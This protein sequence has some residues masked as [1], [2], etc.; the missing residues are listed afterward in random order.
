MNFYNLRALFL[1]LIFLLS[2]FFSALFSPAFSQE[3]ADP[4]LDHL[5][6]ATRFFFSGDLDSAEKEFLFTLALNPRL[7]RAHFGLGLIYLRRNQLEEAEKSFRGAIEIQREYAPAFRGLGEVYEQKKDLSNA[8]IHFQKAVSLEKVNSAFANDV[9]IA[10]YHLSQIGDTPEKAEE[11]A[12]R[13]NAASG[14]LKLKKMELALKGFQSVIEIVPDQLDALENVA[15]ISIQL[16]RYAE[17]GKALKKI[18][19]VNPDL[20]FA[21]FLLGTLYETIGQVGEA[22]EEY[23]LVVKKGEKT[24]DSQDLVKTKKRLAQIGPTRELAVAVAQKLREASELYKKE[25]VDEAEA[26]YN[27]ILKIVPNNS[28]AQYGLGIIL[29]KKGK[30]EE[31][32]KY[33]ENAVEDDP[34]LLRGHFFLGKIYLGRKE[35]QKGVTELNRVLELGKTPGHEKEFKAEI[36]EAKLSLAQMG[37]DV[38]IAAEVQNFLDQGRDLYQKEDIEGAREK[39]S[40]VLSLAPENLEALEKLGSIYLRETSLDTQ[41]AK[42]TFERMLAI[43]PELLQTRIRLAL[44]YEADEEF[45]KAIGQLQEVIRRDEK[46]NDAVL[47]AKKLFSQMGGTAEKAKALF[48][49]LKEG[50]RLLSEKK[51]KEAESVYQKAL[52]IVQDQVQA[53]YSLGLILLEDK[54]LEEAEKMFRRVIKIDPDHFESHFNLG[55]LF[56]ARGKYADGV[57]ALERAVSIG[58]EGK[59]LIEAKKALEEMKQKSGAETHFNIGMETLKK[60]TELEKTEPPRPGAA[61]SEAKKNLIENAVK[62]ME[63]AAK[64]NRDNPYYLYNLALTYIFKSDLVSAEFLLKRLVILKPEMMIAHYRLALLY[65]AAGAVSAALREYQKVIETGKEEDEEVKEAHSKLTGLQQSLESKEEA[66]GYS[67]VGNALFLELKMKEKAEYFLKKA[68]EIDPKNGDYWYDLG[69]YEEAAGKQDEAAGAYQE[70]IHNSPN[71]SKPYFY[72]GIIQEKKGDSKSAYPNFVKAKKYMVDLNSKEYRLNQER[73]EFYEK[74]ASG[75]LTYSFFNYDSNLNS[76][77]QEP[78]FREIYSTYIVSLKYF[79]LK[80]LS[81]L[82]SSDFSSSN[83]F[84]Y[85]SQGQFNSQTLSFESKWVDFHGLTVAAGPA[86]GVNFA[87]GGMSGWNSR[88]KVDFQEKW[89]WFDAVITH[90][91]YFYSVSVSN[92][93][94]DST[95]KNISWNFLKNSFYSGYLNLVCGVAD[96][97][98][99]ASDNSNTSL[100]ATAVYGRLLSEYLNGSLVL[101]IGR[102]YFKNPDSSAVQAGRTSYRMNEFLNVSGSVNYILFRNMTLSGVIG[103]LAVRS[104]RSISDATTQNQNSQAGQ[105]ELLTKQAAPIGGYQKYT[106]GLSAN[107]SF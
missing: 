52:E 3:G 40:K 43:K 28:R 72:L 21:H 100:N 20:L 106:I 25:K 69:I 65:D 98:F 68:V 96:S 7:H 94:F 77:G 87:F 31:S 89:G 8:V 9:A 24:P 67:L 45:D 48:A 34:S 107:Y 30:E 76:S 61:P 26:K 56:G 62:E 44:L 50:N 29:F 33:F 38:T 91:D 58:R 39:F 35:I 84:Y 12:K 59:S 36:D 103:F 97:E 13:T 49:D 80:S 46:G 79:Y 15:V 90:L 70:S 19:T 14:L 82:L 53:L 42:E 37:S 101:G 63:A 85:Y 16:G 23:D 71:F 4:A 5:Q 17:G 86:F 54:K 51:L 99:V 55:L 83:S 105:T 41:K 74:K 18:I 102:S 1:I 64:L 32:K 78:F 10:R 11:A 73:V 95:Q 47:R 93:Y 81:L 60:I 6:K 92:P 27:E 22:W 66:K 88:L 57:E 75:G 2:I 104:N